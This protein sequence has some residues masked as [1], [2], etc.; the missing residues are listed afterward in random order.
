MGFVDGGRGGGVSNRTGVKTGYLEMPDDDN[1]DDDIKSRQT[2]FF[3]FFFFAL[4]FLGFIG[5]LSHHLHPGI[6]S[7]VYQ[8][9]IGS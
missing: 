1:D 4:H 5:F 6:Q 9:I 2:A 3:F 8:I 7:S